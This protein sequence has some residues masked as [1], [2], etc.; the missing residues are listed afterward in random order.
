MDMLFVVPPYSDI[1]HPAIGV[2]LLQAQVRRAGFTSKTCYF[3]LDLAEQIGWELYRWL[4]LCEEKPMLGLSACSTSMIGEWFFSDVAFPGEMAQNEKEYLARFLGTGAV[5]QEL[6]QRILK[7]R[8]IRVQFVEQ[9][10]RKIEKFSPRVVG[11]TSSFHQTCAGLAIA[12]WLKENSTPP[13]ILM[14][15][16][17]CAGEMG[18]QMLRSFPWLD[19][20]CTGEADEALPE[21]LGR[22]L[23]K[24][25]MGAVPGI[26]KQ[27]EAAYAGAPAPVRDMDAL[28]YPDYSDYFERLRSFS[29]ADRITARLPLETSRGC[30]W[31]EKHHCTFCGLNGE[32]MVYRSKSPQ[33]VLREISYLRETYGLDRFLSVDNILDPHYMQTVF[34][35]LIESGVKVELFY[36][37]KS[38]LSFEQLRLLRNSGVTTIQ[39]GIESFSNQVLGLMRKGCTGVQNLQLLRWCEELGIVVCW[40]IIYGFP[41]ESPREY[42]RMAALVPMLAHLQPPAFCTAARMDRFS[43]LFSNPGGF[44]LLRRHPIPAYDYVFPLK[45]QALER[46]AYHFDFEYGDGREPGEYV[47]ELAREV[48]NWAT[49]RDQQAAQ[50]DLYLAGSVALISDSRPCAKKPVHVLSGSAAKLYL[51]CDRAQTRTSLALQLGSSVTEEKMNKILEEFLAAKLV[52]EWEGRYLSLAVFRNRKETAAIETDSAEEQATGAMLLNFS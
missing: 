20:V 49:L 26:L 17:N 9:C 38:N 36:A 37:T 34:P 15:G 46:L 22:L 1:E 4:S 6:I 10:V 19:Y 44:G 29:F 16:A 48:K 45:R 24:G 28:P 30:W 33:R 7:A 25:D 47:G 27:G 35:D 40:N 50:L 41:Y 52:I 32:T 39:P 51:L 31:G 18:E 5:E 23:R 13:V 14:G 3:N 11:L 21:F 8:E 43:P 2:S 12:R 42:K